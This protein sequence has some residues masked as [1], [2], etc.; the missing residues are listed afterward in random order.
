MPTEQVITN[1][2]PPNTHWRMKRRRLD[3]VDV[4]REG[5]VAMHVKV[6]IAHG[7]MNTCTMTALF[8]F[9]NGKSKAKTVYKDTK[10]WTSMY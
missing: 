3:L 6:L 5:C 2:P 1:V 10:G 8:K 7:E 4:V 9:K